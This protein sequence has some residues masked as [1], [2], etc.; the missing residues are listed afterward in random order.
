MLKSKIYL[1]NRADPSKRCL[2]SYGP[3]FRLPGPFLS[4]VPFSHFGTKPRTRPSKGWRTS[5]S[6]DLV[7]IE[8]S[9]L[10]QK[11]SSL[12]PSFPCC[13]KN[14]SI[15]KK[16]CRNNFLLTCPTGIPRA[17]KCSTTFN[18]FVA[19]LFDLDRKYPDMIFDF[20]SPQ[21][22]KSLVILKMM[23]TEKKIF[24]TSGSISLVLRMLL[25]S[26]WSFVQM[27]LIV[28]K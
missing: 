2:N 12:P 22:S 9:Q 10:G 18:F 3:T 19:R 14:P 15:K 7:H 20:Y 4:R 25:K 6:Q 23:N 11:Q 5:F 16:L 17:R 8:V 27:F 28:E 21:N 26:Q 13:K 24:H 1:C